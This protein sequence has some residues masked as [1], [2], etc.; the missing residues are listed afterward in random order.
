MYNLLV[1]RAKEGK[2][3][4]GDCNFRWLDGVVLTQKMMFKYRTE[5]GEEASHFDIWE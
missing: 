4:E 2:S 5:G 3:G 1:K